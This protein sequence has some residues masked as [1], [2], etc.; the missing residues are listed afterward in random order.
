MRTVYNIRKK[1]KVVE[2]AG[3]SQM[4]QLMNNLAEHNYIVVHRSCPDTDIVKDL[5]WDHPTSVELLN[6]FPCVFMMNWKRLTG[7]CY[8]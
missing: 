3:R 1:F 5:L 4:Q 6:A 8:P 2:Y 7:I